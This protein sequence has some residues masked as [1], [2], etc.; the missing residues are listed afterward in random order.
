MAQ[1]VKTIQGLAI[2][3]VKTTQGLAI[4]SAKTI[5]G[6]D[7]TGGGGGGAL[8]VSVKAGSSNG[9]S[10]TSSGIDTTGATLLVAVMG[11]GTG[12]TPSFTDSKGNTWTAWTNQAG[13]VTS[14]KTYRCFPTTVGAGHTFTG[15]A[16]GG[17]PSIIVAAFSGFTSAG[18]EQGTNGGSST[19][20]AAGSVTPAGDNYLVVATVADGYTSNPTASIDGGFTIIQ[21]QPFTAA[22]YFGT[23]MAYLIQTSAAAANPTWTFSGTVA[24]SA[25]TNSTYAP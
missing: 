11:Y 21:D 20:F 12:A 23:A 19:T 14:A 25:G 3:S 17:A 6:V 13:G 24:E 9:D 15:T 5:I 7:N 16:T 1:L 18:T 2:A 4:A 8:L 10:V 22:T